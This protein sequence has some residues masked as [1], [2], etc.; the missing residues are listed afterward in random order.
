MATG[1]FI[2]LIALCITILALLWQI[3]SQ[4]QETQQIERRTR[5][6]LQI[7]EFC[8]NQPRNK[9]EIIKHIQEVSDKI[10]P[11]DVNKAL[12]EMLADE[13]LRYRS[14]GTF[15]ARRNRARDEVEV[16]NSEEA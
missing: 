14:N 15:K 16:E 13:T 3:R 1:D 4:R 9:N 7:F 12:Y 10:T 2:Q 11:E 8:E 5:Y 6:K